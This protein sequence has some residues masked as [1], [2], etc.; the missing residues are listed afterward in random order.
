M[1]F[2]FKTRIKKPR[3]YA[4]LVSLLAIALIQQL[5]FRHEGTQ[6]IHCIYIHLFFAHP[7]NE[8]SSGKAVAVP[9]SVII[10]CP[11]FPT[12]SSIPSFP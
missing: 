8:S 9:S 10:H 11:F 1:L 5:L 4:L 6:E 12:P 7:T 3:S 2:P